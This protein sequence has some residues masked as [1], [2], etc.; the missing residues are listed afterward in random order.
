MSDTNG[1]MEKR[2]FSGFKEKLVELCKEGP[3]ETL[4]TESL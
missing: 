2:K 3:G 1:T 4:L